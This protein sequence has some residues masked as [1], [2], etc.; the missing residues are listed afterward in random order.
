MKIFYSL[1]LMLLPVSYTIAQNVAINTDG[2][3][4]SDPKAMLEIKKPG[5]SKLKIRSTGYLNDTAVLELSNRN[6]VEEGTD[7]IFKH[8]RE[9]ALVLSSLSDF[10]TNTRDSIMTITPQGSI[11]FRSL[12]GTGTRQVTANANGE[13]NASNYTPQN[14]YLNISVGAFQPR[15][16]SSVTNFTAIDANSMAYFTTG[17]NNFV[18]APVNLPHGAVV[19][20]VKVYFVDNSASDIFFSLGGTGV[21]ATSTFVLANLLSSGAS[22]SNLTVSSLEATSITMATI[23]NLNNAYHLLAGPPGGCCWDGVSLRIKS[24]VITY[25]L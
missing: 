22:G 14:Q 1:T 9:Q 4:S 16:N 12:R 18:V 8:I 17:T 15:F 13:I 25:L 2:T 24:V 21:N 23:D 20:S 3:S 5:Y 6:A 10:P 19:T 7:F 11:R